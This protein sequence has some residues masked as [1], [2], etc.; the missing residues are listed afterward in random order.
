MTAAAEAPPEKFPPTFYY[1]NAM[2]LFERLAHY[3]FY[4]GLSLYLSNIVKM[5]D[6]EVGI[7]LGNWRLAASLAPI[8][9]GAIADRIT[10]KRSLIIAFS[11]YA[12]AYSVILLLPTRAFVIPALFLAALAGGFM[13]PVI[14]GTVVRTS[15]P[16]RQTE[17]FG[18]FYRMI[19]TGS[20]VGKTLAY[21]VRRIV[22]LRFV[23]GTSV[24]AS[25]CA[26]ALAIFA[27]QEPKGGEQVGQGP[28]LAETLRGYGTALRNLRFV[29]FLIVFAGFYFMAEQFY[30]T[31][32]KYVTRHIDEKAPLE[33]ITLVN[34]ALIALFQGRVTKIM[35]RIDPVWT[36]AM[37]VA[38]GATSMLVMGAIPTIVGALL[39]G[40]IFALAE[41]TFSPRFFDYIASFAPKG[42]AGMY[43]GLAFVPAA[44]GAWVGGQASG[45]LIAK[46]LPKEGARDPFAIWSIYATLGVVCALAM[47]VYGFA[48]RAARRAAPAP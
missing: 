45:F 6:I 18:V 40:A 27:Y 16:G 29:S 34:P 26:L 36:M 2:E 14:M 48:T 17:G 11:L 46:Y 8:P 38:I 9:C 4:I 12:T 13:K 35:K 47:V 3:G 33:L 32:P 15:P 44:I 41:M 1:A 28:A 20:V 37:G 10:F 42:K 31:F 24:I 22:A 39:S 43:M 25:L 19:N 7:V 30:M 21:G 5:S 23:A